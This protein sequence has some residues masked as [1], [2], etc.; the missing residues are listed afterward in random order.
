MSNRESSLAEVLEHFALTLR[1]TEQ[2]GGYGGS[3]ELDGWFI[4]ISERINSD[5]ASV[6]STT[7]QATGSELIGRA[8]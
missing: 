4:L 8:V 6:P 7:P 3:F 5:R 1:C 2:P